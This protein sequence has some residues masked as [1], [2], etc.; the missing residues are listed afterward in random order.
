MSA[1][2]IDPLIA[3]SCIEDNL[4]LSV[5]YGE[6]NDGG[7]VKDSDGDDFYANPE[8]DGINFET[9]EGFM[10]YAYLLGKQDGKY[11]V[12]RNIKQALDL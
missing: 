6:L 2:Y 11:E 1:H 10:N 9:I 7:V 12:Q 3:R 5:A 8:Y 4:D